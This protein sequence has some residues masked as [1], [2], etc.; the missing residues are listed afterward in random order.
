MREASSSNLGFSRARFKKRGDGR[1]SER[2]Q[3]SWNDDLKGKREETERARE[4][5]REEGGRERS[6][7]VRF[8]VSS[9]D[10]GRDLSIRESQQPPFVAHSSTIC[11]ALRIRIYRSLRQSDDLKFW[12]NTTPASTT[13]AA[14]SSFSRSSRPRY[15]DL[16]RRQS[17]WALLFLYRMLRRNWNASL[18]LQ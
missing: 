5:E 3:P 9:R 1:V 11:R 6:L 10:G 15:R 4:R 12:A 13:T 14:R 18:Q 16:S 2:D 17:N 7:R 8:L